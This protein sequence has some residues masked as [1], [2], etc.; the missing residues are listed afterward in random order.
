ML[1]R[2]YSYPKII[3]PAVGLL[4]CWR[5][6]DRPS[7]WRLAAISIVTTIAFYLRFDYGAL[8][9]VAVA[10]ALL[11]RHW[12]AWREYSLVA[13]RFGL[14]VALLCAPYVLFQ[15]A[16]GELTSGPGSGRLVHLLRGDDV[17]SLAV[18]DLP[19][20]RPLVSFREAGPLSTVRWSAVI[21]RRQ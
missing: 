15:L 17:V 9:G 16:W 18:P 4:V 3:V 7:P 19:E 1:P 14:V 6:I 12:G 11:V 2:L 5:Y 21:D 10:A 13:L 8:F 20:E